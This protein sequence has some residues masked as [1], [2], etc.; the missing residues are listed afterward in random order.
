MMLLVG[1][2]QSES[3]KPESEQEGSPTESKENQATE[4]KSVNEEKQEDLPSEEKNSNPEE[5]NNQS[6][7][8]NKAEEPKQ[9]DNPESIQVLV[10]K[11]NLL[12]E[13]YEPP[14]LVKPDVPFYFDE[15]LPK[16]YMREEAAAALEELFK[17]TQAVNLNLVAASGFRSYERQERIYQANV[18][19]MGQEAA[20]KVSAF[21][22]ASEHQTGLAIDVTSPQMGYGLDEAFGQTPEGEWLAKHAYKYGFIIRYPEGRTKETGYQYEPW[23]LRYIG[24]K[25]AKEIHQEELILEEYLQ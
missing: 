13:G 6:S 21:P 19:K 18:E 7:K 25:A 5:S 15:D 11:R 20:D 23:H 1:C 24:E 3:T 8:D 12:P 16:R 22:G 14:D 10:N 4:K 9:V 17:A 2:G